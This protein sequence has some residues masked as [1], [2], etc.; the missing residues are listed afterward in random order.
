MSLIAEV[1]RASP[2]RGPIR[3]DLDVGQ[4]VGDYTKAGAKAVSVLT[5]EDFFRG[6]LADLGVAAAHTSLPLLR[7]DFVV[8]PYQIH[9]ARAYGASAILLIVA[10]LDERQ[11]EELAQTACDEGLDVLVEVHDTTEIARALAIDA[12]GVVIGINNRDL[13]TFTVSLE[14]TVHL[15]GVVPDGH[16]VVSESGVRTCKDIEKLAALGIDGVLVGESLLA[17]ADVERAVREL[18]GPALA[19]VA[20][21]AESVG[22]GEDR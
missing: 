11:L 9:E 5:E 18:M 10:L 19:E 13:N 16:L 7:K 22:R 12:E 8:D 1:K 21:S 2:S 20:G 17:E 14:T 15:A 3:L 6:S 4:V